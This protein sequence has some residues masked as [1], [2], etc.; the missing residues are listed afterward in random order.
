MKHFIARTCTVVKERSRDDWQ[1]TESNVRHQAISRPLEFFRTENAYVLLGSPGSGKTTAFELEAKSK[2]A[3]LVSARDF[4]TFRLKSEWS[5]STVFIDGLD[6]MRAGAHDGRTPLDNIRA[7][8]Q[9]L[10]KPRFRLSCRE[11]D[12]FGA[13]DRKSLQAVAPA[14]EL[15]ILRLD[16]LSDQGIAK[17][18]R[19]ICGQKDPAIFEH[20]ARQHGVWSLLRNPLNLEMLIDAVHGGHWPRTKAEIFRLA[21]QKLISEKNDEHQ[22]AQRCTANVQELLDAAGNIFAVLLLSGKTGITLR[23]TESDQ[24]HPRLEHMSLPGKQRCSRVVST[25]LFASTDEGRLVPA[26]RQLA[27][28]LA[29]RRFARLMDE[30]LSYQRVLS[31]LTGLDGGIVSEFRGLAAWLAT[32]SRRARRAIVER[33]PIG[34]VLY[35]EI[36][37]FSINEK[38][39]VFHYLERD[40]GL[41]PGL[42]RDS[43]FD[44]RPGDLVTPYLEKQ[45]RRALTTP[46][47]DDAAAAIA[48]VVL[49]ALSASD[50]PS[51][52]NDELFRIVMDSGWPPTHRYLALKLCIQQR[53]QVKTMTARLLDTLSHVYHTE[54]NLVIRDE[55]SGRLLSELYGSEMSVAEAAQYLRRPRSQHVYD[56][57]TNF[58]QKVAIERSRPDQLLE[59]L[60]ILWKRVE[61]ASDLW[62]P[63]P[64][65]ADFIDGL[66]GGC[67]ES[68]IKH[69]PS[70]VT[71]PLLYKW[72]GTACSNLL[73]GLDTDYIADWLS[74]QGSLRQELVDLAGCDEDR[75][76]ARN[77]ALVALQAGHIIDRLPKD[78]QLYNVSKPGCIGPAAIYHGSSNKRH[79]RDPQFGSWLRD[80]Q[81]CMRSHLDLVQP[82]QAPPELIHN[83]A[84][85][86]LGYYPALRA[87]TGKGRLSR[88]LGHQKDLVDA[89]V[90]ALQLA[91]TR[92][93]LPTPSELEEHAAEG[94]L[95]MLAYPVLAGLRERAG[96]GHPV[97]LSPD[98]RQ[99]R[100]ALTIWYTTDE[101]DC[102]Y[103]LGGVPAWLTAL[104]KT[105]PDLV[106]DVLVSV[107]STFMRSGRNPRYGFNGLIH[108][109][110][111]DQLARLATL[112][113]LEVFPVRCHS[114]LL[115]DLRDLLSAAICHCDGSQLIDLI[116]VK[117]GYKSMH[118]GQR[119]YWLTVGHI[120]APQEYSDFLES[121]AVKNEMRVGHC[122][123]MLAELNRLPRLVEETWTV[124]VLAPLIRLLGA[125][126]NPRP[127]PLP[128]VAYTVTDEMEIA[129]FVSRLINRLATLPSEIATKT[130]TEL[131]ASES[132]VHWSYN[133]SAAAYRQRSSRREASFQHPK[134]EQA[135]EVLANQR[136]ANAA[137][138]A[139]ITTDALERISKR[140]RSSPTSD[141]RQYWNVDKHN[142]PEKPK[143]ENGCRDALLSDLQ[144]ELKPMGIEASKEGSYVND[145][146]SDIR[147]AYEGGFNVPVEIKRSCHREWLNSIKTQLIKKYACDPN[148]NGYGIYLVFWFG[149]S[150][151]CRPAPAL[152]H[153]P[154][155]PDE[156]RQALLDFL[157]DSE[158]RKIEVCIIDVSKPAD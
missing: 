20:E 107:S 93:D 90:S 32:Q 108:P 120:L 154:K 88:M 78:L 137:D 138:L 74:A 43:S 142:R 50:V 49:R 100:I 143:P 109:S 33:D 152:G 38:E 17:M 123:A 13:N 26:H 75:N 28:F 10:G 103:P 83:L 91:I 94:R 125:F 133:L 62:D 98:D 89:A 8:L 56:S 87:P 115:P 4:V 134:M 45:F 84:L 41:H 18:L 135:V 141:W 54:H 29:A 96:T 144:Y 151:G 104:I 35:G 147:V 77:V 5:N 64:D 149:A 59:L 153:T 52:F 72:L 9:E 47:A 131:R 129:S 61:E 57:Y 51:G 139:A 60:S 156:L 3:R 14:G 80:I 95:H 37:R 12:W 102:E 44:A 82:N 118:K 79:H 121:F 150:D 158:R 63:G 76:R 99:A 92:P 155:S 11:A 86:Y 23:G 126:Y 117:L 42:L 24:D 21:C 27:E 1:A 70:E 157:S 106:A 110:E 46:P 145:K 113:L 127:E 124:P 36:R 68:L 111:N 48:D 34:V 71:P 114:R 148:T 7:K 6:E 66:P 53:E 140:I 112:R 146:R 97:S 31:L 39:L 16:P 15:I 105:R 136:P 85:A 55:I 40:L 2:G 69:S 58:W 101:P 128:G 122:A 132:L 67:L 65:G 130:L 19:Y 116:G 25:N 22:I 73:E 30:G 81:D 119:A